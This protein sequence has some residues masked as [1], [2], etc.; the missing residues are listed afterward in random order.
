MRAVAA[1]VAAAGFAA[2]VRWRRQRR[3]GSVR[4]RVGEAEWVLRVQLAA[5]Y[6]IASQRGWDELIYNHIT[7]VV[8]SPEGTRHFLINAFGLRFDEITASNLVK[9]DDRNEVVD[10][11]S[12]PP[13]ALSVNFAGFVIHGAVHAARRDLP[14]V[15]HTHYTPLAATLCNTAHGGLLPLSQEACL[16]WPRVSRRRHPYEGI[17]SSLDEQA[18]LVDALGPHEVLLMENH[19]VLVGG[20]SAAACYYTLHLLCRAAE[21]QAA[22]LAA[23]GGRAEALGLVPE[24][25]VAA[26]AERLAVAEARSRAPEGAAAAPGWGELEWAAAVR[27]LKRDRL[28]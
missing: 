13:S 21:H 28:L 12:N 7:H 22:T 20:A 9:I 24:A 19:G 1:A 4:A 6:R 10:G 8:P 17:A 27:A 11:G 14:C 26:T 15:W 5:A 3:L 25:V 18:R 23:A 2:W 16:V